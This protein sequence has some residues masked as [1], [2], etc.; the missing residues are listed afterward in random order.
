[1]N[2]SQSSAHTE[3][4]ALITGA[5]IG[6]GRITALRLAQAGFT[7]TEHA[8][9]GNNGLL[10]VLSSDCDAALALADLGQT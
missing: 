10:A 8:I 1:M 5:N 2:P 3:R 9:D 7:C 4:V 6:I